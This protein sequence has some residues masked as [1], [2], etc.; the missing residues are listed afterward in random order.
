MEFKNHVNSPN[1]SVIY[2]MY[3]FDKTFYQINTFFFF[4]NMKH[5]IF[6]EAN[7]LHGLNCLLINLF[8]D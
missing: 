8:H 3:S 1:G 6:W 2:W 5:S 7:A 4:F